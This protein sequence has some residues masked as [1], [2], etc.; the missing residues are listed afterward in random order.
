MGDG[1]GRK[2]DI[3]RATACDL[4]RYVDFAAS[5]VFCLRPHGITASP[6]RMGFFLTFYFVSVRSTL[7]SVLGAR[8]AYRGSRATRR[9]AY[10]GSIPWWPA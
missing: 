5:S 4:I 8:V 7:V 10:C 2:H 1:A 9:W 3:N 6:E